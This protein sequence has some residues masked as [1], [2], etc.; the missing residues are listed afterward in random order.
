MSVA[1]SDGTVY[2]DSQEWLADSF[3]KMPLGGST[4]PAGALKPT[5]GTQVPAEGEKVEYPT[6]YGLNPPEREP[7][8]PVERPLGK[9]LNT[10]ASPLVNIYE[11]DVEDAM[12]VGMSGGTGTLMG[13]KS[14]TF[15][16]TK[17][18]Q[19]QMLE[20]ETVHPDEIWKAT[21]TYR[22]AEGRWKQEISDKNAT[23]NKNAFDIEITPGSPGSD[24]PSWTDI[25]GT[26][27]VEKWVPRGKGLGGLKQLPDNASLSEMYDFLKSDRNPISTSL[28]KALNHPELFKAYPELR[29]IKV[30]EYIPQSAEDN[31]LGQVT[32]REIHLRAG[33]PELLRSV[34]LHEVQHQIQG[35]EGF[36]RGGMAKEFASPEFEVIKSNFKKVETEAYEDISKNYPDVP[37]G[38][39]DD[40]AAVAK[41][42]MESP[43]SHALKDIEDVYREQ[44][45]GVYEK[46]MN[47]IRTKHL[48][49][50]KEAQHLERYRRL[51]GEVESRNVQY[52]MDMDTMERFLRS[53][54]STEDRPRF[55]QIPAEQ[56][57]KLQFTPD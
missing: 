11:R 44:F 1:L 2:K 28:D 40:M 22:G 31:I 10:T 8:V 46:V 17:L 57:K 38:E 18:R 36:S 51:Q 42:V 52:R 56:N 3:S 13:V 48:I 29:S 24:K 6:P 33:H 23:L 39:V 15:N 16:A 32:G 4:E 43:E 35:I 25:S 53:P 49:E 5:G 12:S 47:I 37:K 45:P 19:A 7:S 50:E 41:S 26:E 54:K 27:D 30:M 14:A 34:L 21:G 55:V 9:L 20:G